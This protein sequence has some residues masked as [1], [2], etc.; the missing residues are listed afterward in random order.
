MSLAAAILA[1]WALVCVLAWPLCR[2]AALG[3]QQ[4]QFRTAVRAVR[5]PHA[6]DELRVRTVLYGQRSGTVE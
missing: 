5:E 6:G 3:D 4:Q 2:A 1:G